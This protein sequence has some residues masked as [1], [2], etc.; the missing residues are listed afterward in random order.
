MCCISWYF[1]R[2]VEDYDDCDT[3]KEFTNIRHYF[4]YQVGSHVTI[5]ATANTT[6]NVTASVTT[7]TTVNTAFNNSIIQVLW[8]AIWLKN[9]HVTRLITELSLTRLWH[10]L[11]HTQIQHSEYNSSL[12]LLLMTDSQVLVAGCMSHLMGRNA[13]KTLTWWL[14]IVRIWISGEMT[15][16]R[17]KHYQSI[18]LYCV[19]YYILNSGL[20]AVVDGTCYDSIPVG[21]VTIDIHVQNCRGYS[22]D[23][24]D[25]Y[26]TSRQLTV[27]EIYPQSARSKLGELNG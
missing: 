8:T 12:L 18:L 15:T 22:S 17:C 7:N 26:N 11:S 14:L 2:L 4:A 3:S 27:M 1:L 19:Q 25:W 21:N 23:F 9:I 6:T 16:V 20:F 24:Q 13:L 10:T 5:N